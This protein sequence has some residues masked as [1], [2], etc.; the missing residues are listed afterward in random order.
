[1]TWII[2]LLAFLLST[3]ALGLTVVGVNIWVGLARRGPRAAEEAYRR[4]DSIQAWLDPSKSAPVAGP[5]HDNRAAL[6]GRKDRVR[7]VVAVSEHASDNV[8]GV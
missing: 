8:Y 5:Q 3:V 4:G 6:A 2:A 1:M 7:G